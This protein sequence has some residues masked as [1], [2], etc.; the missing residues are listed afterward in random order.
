MF[1][2]DSEKEQIGSNMTDEYILGDTSMRAEEDSKKEN[3]SM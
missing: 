3:A 2:A 1:N